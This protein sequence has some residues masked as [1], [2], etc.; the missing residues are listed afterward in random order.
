M[1][2]TDTPD[3]PLSFPIHFLVISYVRQGQG[4][5]LREIGAFRFC[6]VLDCCVYDSRGYDPESQIDMEA[7]DKAQADI[8]KS[9]RLDFK[10]VRVLPAAHILG[11]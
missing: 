8:G 2:P 11:A 3:S 6:D 1:D 4:R 10:R 9:V 5:A 7:L